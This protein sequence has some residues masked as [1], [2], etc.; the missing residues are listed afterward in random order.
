MLAAART[1]PARPQVHVL[2]L[3]SA[4]A[5][6]QLHDARAQGVDVT[7]ETCPH[8]LAFAAEEI[9]DGATVQVRAADPRPRQPRAAVGG[10]GSRRDRHD[11]LRPLS[12]TADLKRR[13]TVDFAT[14]WGG[15]AS[16]EV[17]LPVV[18]TAARARGVALAR[19]ARWMASAPAD[20]VGLGRK[21]RI[22]V[23]ADADLVVFDPDAEFIVDASRLHQRNP[24]SAYD[25]RRLAGVVRQ[26]W[27]RGE[28]VEAASAVGHGTLLA[29]RGGERRA[30]VTRGG[31]PGQ[32][33]LA[34]DRMRFTP[35]YAPSAGARCATS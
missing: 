35:A 17:D 9:D 28:R 29:R 26:T 5:L 13:D 8:Y 25:G 24:V 30:H 23:G 33:E 21:G 27:L 32:T 12:C 10:A 4:G 2:H 7:V 20:R 22:A 19:V 15:I 1:G 6:A 11:R 3:S 16:L 14:A 34:S 18:W 31:L